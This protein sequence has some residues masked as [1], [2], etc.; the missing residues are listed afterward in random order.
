MHNFYQLYYHFVWTT[1]NRMPYLVSDV[2]DIVISYIPVKTSKLNCICHEVG[3]VDDHI[4]LAAS[5]P[6]N[7][8]LSDFIQEVKGSCTHLINQSNLNLDY[9]FQWQSGYGVVSFDK[10]ALPNIRKYIINQRQHH[11]DNTLIKILEKIQNNSP[12]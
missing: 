3:M 6:P 4:H 1:K 5:I 10:K 9:Q 7:L 11:Q 2:K 12:L 8:S